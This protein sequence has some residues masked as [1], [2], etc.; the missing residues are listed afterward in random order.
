MMKIRKK[1]NNMS[2]SKL[3]NPAKLLLSVSLFTFL[4]SACDEDSHDYVYC[5][6]NGTANTVYLSYQI[7]N[8]TKMMY[9]TLAPGA[10]DTLCLRSDVSGNDVW[11]VETG[12]EIFMLTSLE[13]SINDSI[14]TSDAR[15]RSSWGAVSDKNGVGVYNLTLESGMFGIAKRSYFYDVVNNSGYPISFNLTASGVKQLVNMD[16]SKTLRFGP[17]TA[18]QAHMTDLYATGAKLSQ[19]SL[20]VLEQFAGTDTLYSNNLNPNKASS[21]SFTPTVVGKDSVGIYKLVVTA[22]NF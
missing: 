22:D 21:W 9:D 13:A 3:L 16:N 8:Q 1:T 11:N 7:Y 12:S 2:I 6:T 5:V 14:Y 20:S 18:K 17:Y 15:L 4:F 10:T 19:I